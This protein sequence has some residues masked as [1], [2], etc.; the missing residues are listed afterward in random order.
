MNDVVEPPVSKS[1]TVICLGYVEYHQPIM[2]SLGALLTV[3]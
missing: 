1:A 2:D 3:R